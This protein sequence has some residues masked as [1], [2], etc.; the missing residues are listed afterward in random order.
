M[1]LTLA[2]PLVREFI[3]K[4][5]GND[6]YR[7]IKCLSKGLTD[8]Q[9]SKKTRLEVNE[10]RA[11]LNRLHYLG[12]IV[13][14][15]EKAARSNWYTYTWFLKPERINELLLDNLQ[16]EREK[17]ARK[18]EMETGYVFFKCSNGCEK[19]PF[20]L[21]FEYDFKCP[22]CGN[23]MSQQGD[24]RELKTIEKR[25]ELVERSLGKLARNG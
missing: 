2:S 21:A 4:N 16:E 10:I 15:K 5:A 8:E 12:V 22:E 11:A 9:I 7:V 1:K 24:S 14:S 19:L 25:I 20:E 3:G 18:M 13:Y 6:A 17:L 23:P